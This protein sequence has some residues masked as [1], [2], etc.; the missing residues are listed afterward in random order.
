MTPQAEALFEFIRKAIDSELVKKLTFLANYDRPRMAIREIVDMPDRRIHL[1]MR[2]CLQNNKLLS[3]SKRASHFA[4]LP[5]LE[6]KSLERVFGEKWG[7]R[8]DNAIYRQRCR[9]LHFVTQL[10][11][12]SFQKV[13]RAKF[14]SAAARFSRRRRLRGKSA[15]CLK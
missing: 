2:F 7:N 15:A 9:S 3:L 5:D 11:I 6:T 10:R 12:S 1:F 13:C 4:S 14:K 8:G